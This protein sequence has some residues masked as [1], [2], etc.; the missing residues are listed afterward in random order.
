MMGTQV[1]QL[2]GKNICQFLTV[3]H[4]FTIQSGN[5]IPK[6]LPPQNKKHLFT[7]KP[8]NAYSKRHYSQYQKVDQVINKSNGV[9]PYIGMKILI[10]ATKQINLKILMLSKK[11]GTETKNTYCMYKSI[12]KMSRKSKS[13]YR[14]VHL[15]QVNFMSYEL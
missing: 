5:P 3:K 15:N 4:I 10:H 14:I 9:F 2:L 11:R 6:Y 1:S 7:L 8:A 12:Y 13:T